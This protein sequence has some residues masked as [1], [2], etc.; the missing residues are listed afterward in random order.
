MAEYIPAVIHIG[1]PLPDDRLSELFAA[2]VEDGVTNVDGGPIGDEGDL[3]ALIDGKRPLMLMDPDA[4]YGRLPALEA[5]CEHIGLTYRR[6]SDAKYEYEAEIVS[7]APGM[8][9]P[10]WTRGSQ[11]GTAVIGLATVRKLLDAPAASDAEVVAR[12]RVEV[13]RHAPIQVPPLVLVD[14]ATDADAGAVESASA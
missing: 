9:E 11:D 3:E 2:A 5:A 4:S 14:V 12:L 13:A 7:W 1:G 10:R 6:S 8:E